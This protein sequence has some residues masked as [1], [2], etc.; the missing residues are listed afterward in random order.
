M[1]KLKDAWVCQIQ[2]RGCHVDSSILLPSTN[3]PINKNVK[4]K[5]II[6]PTICGGEASYGI[7]IISLQ[8]RTC[9]YGCIHCTP[10][11]IVSEKHPYIPKN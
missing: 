6:S 5:G 9:I 1:F 2:L 4:R 11:H 10:K 7:L 3:N 8:I